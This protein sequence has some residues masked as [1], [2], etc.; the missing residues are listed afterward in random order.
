MVIADAHG[1]TIAYIATRSGPLSLSGTGVMFD[2]ASLFSGIG[3]VAG[4]VV[5]LA[6]LV[7]HRYIILIYS[8]RL[9]PLN[10]RILCTNFRLFPPAPALGTVNTAP[11]S[12]CY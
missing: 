11:A 6:M 5:L 10:V 7:P 1:V 9:F 2:F 4:A 12:H 3:S 8:F